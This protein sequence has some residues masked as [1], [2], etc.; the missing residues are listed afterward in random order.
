MLSRRIDWSILAQCDLYAVDRLVKFEG[1]EAIRTV[2]PM[3]ETLFDR[4]ISKDSVWKEAY[5]AV[6]KAYKNLQ[7]N[8]EIKI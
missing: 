4:K 1:R 8:F 6:C 3:R 2:T 5:E 7:P